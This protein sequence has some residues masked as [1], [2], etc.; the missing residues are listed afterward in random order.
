MA[1]ACWWASFPYIGRL[2]FNGRRQPSGHRSGAA[3]AVGRP[4]GGDASAR[5]A[6]S[7]QSPAGIVAS[8]PP[9]RLCSARVRNGARTA[10]CGDAGIKGSA[11]STSARTS[12]NALITSA[13]MLR[14]SDPMD[15]RVDDGMN[16]THARSGRNS[17]SLAA[18][19]SAASDPPPI[20]RATHR[21]PG[22]LHR[23]N[24]HRGRGRALK[25]TRGTRR[26]RARQAG[27]SR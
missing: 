23:D 21:E 22:R 25:R 2:S 10:P 26:R 17:A 24:P 14:G 13:P 16:E 27:S 5:E 3:Y 6:P 12:P 7:S 19:S 9:R 15:W 4:R 8:F 11:T 20:A 1:G 18:N